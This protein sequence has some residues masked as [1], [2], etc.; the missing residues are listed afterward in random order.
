MKFESTLTSILSGAAVV[1]ALM[2]LALPAGAEELPDYL[3]SR[4]GIIY[5]KTGDS[6]QGIFRTPEN[7]TEILKPGM[8]VGVLPVD[9]VSASRGSI[10]SYYLCNNNLALRPEEVDGQTVYRVIDPK[11]AD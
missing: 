6:T 4:G 10:G 3:T 1:L 5:P 11:L 9:C 7:I 8:L 2:M